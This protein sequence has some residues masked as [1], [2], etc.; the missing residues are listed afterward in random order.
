MNNA[1]TSFLDESF[2]II[3][4]LCSSSGIRPVPQDPTERPTNEFLVAV[5]S[6]SDAG[7]STKEPAY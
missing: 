4:R 5:P 6:T 2:H 3:L 1:N 7:A